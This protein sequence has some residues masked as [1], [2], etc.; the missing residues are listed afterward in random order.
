MKVGG[1]QS[2]TGYYG[3]EKKYLA[4]ARIQTPDH[5]AQSLVTV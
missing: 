2:E 4:L 5:P 3:E 1:P